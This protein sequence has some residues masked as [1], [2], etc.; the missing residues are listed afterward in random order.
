MKQLKIDEENVKIS[1]G[2]IV[3]QDHLEVGEDVALMVKGTITKDEHKD[4]QDGTVNR[5]V[6]VKG[7]IATMIYKEDDKMVTINTEL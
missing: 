7:S 1:A 3:I 6:T 5:I 4:N 2:Y